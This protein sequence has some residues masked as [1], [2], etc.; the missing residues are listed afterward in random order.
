MGFELATFNHMFYRR[1]LA[2]YWNTKYPVNI[3]KRVDRR[4][5]QMTEL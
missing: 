5:K 1:S 2:S 4:I 3:D